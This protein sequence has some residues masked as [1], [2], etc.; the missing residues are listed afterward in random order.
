MIAEFLP[1]AKAELCDAVAYY[2]GELPR[3][4][5]RF[6]DEIDRHITWIAE[7]PEVPRLRDGSYRRVNLSVFPYYLA[8]IVRSN[9]IW[10]LSVAHG[11]SLPEYWIEQT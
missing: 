7:N 10:I 9:I 1:Q 5:Q 6:W 11:H 3:L 4:G 2:E 8:Y